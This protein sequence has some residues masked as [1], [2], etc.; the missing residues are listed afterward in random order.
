MRARCTLR[1]CP[2]IMFT[3]ALASNMCLEVYFV[4]CLFFALI[5]FTDCR[6]IF[7]FLF[8]KLSPFRPYI[9]AKSNTNSRMIWPSRIFLYTPSWEAV[10][11]LWATL[12]WY[13][14][15][16][17]LYVNKMSGELDVCCISL[18][19]YIEKILTGIFILCR[20][21]KLYTVQVDA[22]VWNCMN[23]R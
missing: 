11:R 3:P 8:K 6:S 1:S 16:S 18:L 19:I 20:G 21:E 2:D 4:A 13:L 14:G 23:L 15:Y 9:V 12:L 7:R 22:I 17:R 5:I 10:V